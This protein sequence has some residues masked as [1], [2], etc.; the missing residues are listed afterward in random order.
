MFF[1]SITRLSL[2]SIWYLP[3]FLSSNN[4]SVKQLLITPGFVAGKELIDKNFVF[5][6]VTV[7]NADAD[8]KS[9]RNS[10]PH[11]RAMQR[12][13]TWCDEA[14]YMHWLS[15]KPQIPAWDTICEKM[16]AEGKVSKVRHPSKNHTDKNFPPIKWTKT[17]RVFKPAKSSL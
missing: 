9:F 16:I 3:G 2:R 5:W 11:R 15:E 6:T 4:Q 17:E 12:L 13:P 1:I 14:T 8:M 7:W 10:P